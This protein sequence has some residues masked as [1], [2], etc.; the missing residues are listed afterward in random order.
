MMRSVVRLFGALG[1]SVGSCSPTKTLMAVD[2]PA[3]LAPITATRLTCETVRLTSM[4]VGFSLV[5]TLR[6]WCAGGC[7]EGCHWENHGYKCCVFRNFPLAVHWPSMGATLSL[8]GYVKLTLFMRR[9]TLLRL[10]TPSKGPGSGNTNFMVS[11]LIS[12]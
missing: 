9:M 4:M 11:L 6:S 7:R 10:L 8:V 12:K 1:P 5:G 2:F 3:P